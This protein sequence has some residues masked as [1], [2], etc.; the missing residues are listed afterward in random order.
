MTIKISYSNKSIGK[1]SGNLVLFADEKFSVNGL[2]KHLSNLEFSYINDLLKTSDL[3]KNLFVFELTSKK[4]IILV[5]IKKDLKSFDVENLGAEFYGR[6]NY[7]KKSEYFVNT[8]SITS[9]LENFT[10]LFLHGLKLKSY[11]FNKYKTK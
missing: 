7:G 4:K 11:E 3:K 8:D 10:G 1:S 5:S 2:K 9:K 6:I